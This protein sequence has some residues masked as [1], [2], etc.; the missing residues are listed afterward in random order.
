MILEIHGR[1]NA[2]VVQS[3]CMLPCVQL[4]IFFSAILTTVSFLSDT[5]KYLHNFNIF[6]RPFFQSVLDIKKVANQIPID[7]NAFVTN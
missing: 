5:N 4:E 7:R 1:L 2:N 6:K 3:Q